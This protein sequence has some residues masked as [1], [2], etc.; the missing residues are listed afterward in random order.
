M[1]EFLRKFKEYLLIEG[2]N[3]STVNIYISHI[4]KFL[5]YIKSN[6][7][8]A[9]TNNITNIL[10]NNIINNI[11]NITN[12]SKEELVYSYILYLKGNNY[13]ENTI[14]SNIKAINNLLN[15]LDVKLTKKI[16]FLKVPKRLPEHIDLDYF[17]DRI[18]PMIDEDMFINPL[19]VKTILYFMF[20]T[21][22]RQGELFSLKR[23]HFDFQN[24]TVTI[25]SKKT[26]EERTVIFPKKIKEMVEYYFRTEMEEDNAFNIGKGGVKYI[27]NKLKP[28]FKDI[29]LHAH[30]FRHSFS[31]YL[32]ENGVDL[33]TLK[34]LL[35]HK[36]ILTT[37]IYTNKTVKKIK[38]IYDKH[39]K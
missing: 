5:L 4:K 28:C 29:N 12:S 6:H 26:K 39:I 13:K 34:D 19:K 37:T 22:V 11:T 2:K 25:Y 23:E 7:K 21:G 8:I 3:I 32:L 15:Y 17:T 36:S 10:T 31:I 18:M 24:R 1:K 20:Y 16:K 30:L 9:L 35:G 14:N 33:D 27:F 38:E